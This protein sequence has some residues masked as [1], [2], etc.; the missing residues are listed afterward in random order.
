MTLTVSCRHGLG[1]EV[2][3]NEFR[4]A[5]AACLFREPLDLGSVEHNDRDMRI[6]FL[7]APDESPN[8]PR[9]RLSR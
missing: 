5:R 1:V 4:D 6:G 2:A 7:Q 3:Q 9:D 8:L